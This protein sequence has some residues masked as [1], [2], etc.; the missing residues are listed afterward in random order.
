MAL[1]VLPLRINAIKEMK[2]DQGIS[3]LRLLAKEHP[4][5]GQPCR[6]NSSKIFATMLLSLVAIDFPNSYVSK[7]DFGKRDINRELLMADEISQQS[8]QE[9]DTQF[10]DEYTVVVKNSLTTQGEEHLHFRKG[11][12]VVHKNYGI[13]IFEGASLPLDGLPSLELRYCDGEL[14][15]APWE[16][17][18]NLKIFKREDEVGE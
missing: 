9:A 7:I 18:D 2:T 17:A 1:G 13:G 8:P 6:P 15:L 11:D 16:A 10:V 3:A 4:C 12:Y 14:H 5:K